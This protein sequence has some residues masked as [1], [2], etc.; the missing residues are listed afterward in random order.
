MRRL[1]TLCLLVVSMALVPTIPTTVHATTGT[2]AH[3]TLSNHIASPTDA[4]NT[5]DHTTKAPTGRVWEQADPD[6][7]LSV[8]ALSTQKLGVQSFGKSRAKSDFPF[9]MFN[10]AMGDVSSGFR[11]YARIDKKLG[12]RKPQ[13][14]ALS[15]ELTFSPDFEW[16]A[17]GRLGGLLPGLTGGKSKR[18]WRVQ[19]A[20]DPE[21]KVK[22]SKNLAKQNRGGGKAAI[23]TPSD[24]YWK[25]S[26]ATN[27]VRLI[28]QQN[29]KKNRDGA[30][31]IEVNGQRIA[32]LTDV[33]YDWKGRGKTK[34]VLREGRYLGPNPT[35]GMEEIRYLTTRNVKVSEVDLDIDTPE[36][37][38]LDDA[39]PSTPQD[40]TDD[41]MDETP[42]TPPESSPEMPP[43]MPPN[44]P[45]APTTPL[46]PSKNPKLVTIKW[47]ARGLTTD[48]VA[49]RRF[50]PKT[51]ELYLCSKDV[52]Q[53]SWE[54][55]PGR[56]LGVY[57]FF[58][59]DD[60]K[61]CAKTPHA[62]L[63]YMKNQRP[64]GLFK[65]KPNGGGWRWYA[66]FDGA[67]DGHCKHTCKD[68]K[69]I[70][71]DCNAK[72]AVNWDMKC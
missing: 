24:A 10:D 12:R 43:E 49:P 41:Q 25:P 40:P 33:V 26:P 20:W 51:L 48:A 54:N 23:A 53:F 72:V 39:T 31:S 66:S 17:K 68:G 62:E 4:S 59:V 7:E 8:V 44:T 32:T 22:V 14:I 65:T 57:G 28:V 35:R 46:P 36:D 64:S 27:R 71:G 6:T 50:D 37:W 19:L 3:A 47:S 69:G 52:L 9:I 16:S 2:D 21:G 45:Q 56:G 30:L 58:N 11:E 29:T 60:W 38:W 70:R 55:E 18:S 1:R 63:N 67:D 42:N 34:Y 13:S 61:S 5:T 15:Y